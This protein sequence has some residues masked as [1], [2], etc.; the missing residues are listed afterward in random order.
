MLAHEVEHRLCA[1]VN[2]EVRWANGSRIFLRHMQLEKHKFN[3]QG[4]SIHG[5]GFDE[6]TQFTETQ[7]RFVSLSVRL[8]GWHP[9]PDFPLRMKL[10]FILYGANPGG[11]GHDF[12]KSRMIDI[13]EPYYV[14]SIHEKGQ[15][16]SYRQFI[17]ARAEDNP[18]LLRNDPLYLERLEAAGDPVLVRAMREGDWD[19]VAGSMFGEVWRAQRIIKG[20][21]LDWHVCEPF[22]IPLGWPLWRGGDDG[23]ASP[24]AVYWLARNPDTATIYVVSE[25]YQNRLTPLEL[26]E[27]ILERDKL[28][29]RSDGKSPHPVMNKEILRGNYDSSAFSNVGQSEITRG[30]QMNRMGC[31]WTPCDKWPG[32]R[33]ARVQMLHQLLKPSVKE[34][35]RKPGIV[36]FRNCVDAIRTIPKIMRHKT[37]PED[38]SDDSEIHAFDGS[39]YGVQ[40]KE[41]RAGRVRVM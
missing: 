31:Q 11:V 23:Y 9:P 33:K 38:V 8:G 1:I 16:A 18:E 41:L 35:G 10:P 17:P 19:I 25:I 7:I 27:K 34:Q 12:I 4:Q 13:G 37:D 3:Y 32:S 14:H 39:T 20:E 15:G 2:K 5:A 21:T 29:P 40:F 36:F 6:A 22:P 26:G 28:I 24:S 30:E